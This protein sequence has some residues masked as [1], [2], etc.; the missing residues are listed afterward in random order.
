MARQI[1][2]SCLLLVYSYRSRTFQQPHS[3]TV[4]TRLRSTGGLSEIKQAVCNFQSCASPV[5]IE[6]SLRFN[7][8]RSPPVFISTLFPVS[9]KCRIV[10]VATAAKIARIKYIYKM[11]LSFNLQMYRSFNLQLNQTRR[12]NEIIIRNLK[13]TVRIACDNAPFT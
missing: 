8:L 6:N 7:S 4:R 2:A 11:Y 1:A 12:V 10:D 3:A 5:V 13:L 9:S